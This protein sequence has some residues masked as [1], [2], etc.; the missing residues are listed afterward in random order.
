MLTFL[1][2]ALQLIGLYLLADF[3][4]GIAHYLIDNVLPH[5]RSRVARY[6][7]GENNLHHSK[8]RAML[9]ATRWQRLRV[10]LP[11]SIATLT[12]LGL[13]GLL[14]WQVVTL[15]SMLTVANEIHAFAH[16]TRREN[17]PLVTALQR[18]GFFQSA[19]HH[20]LHHRSPFDCHYCVMSN[21]LNPL[22]DRL[23]LWSRLD[24]MLG[25][26]KPN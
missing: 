8:P 11:F 9:N 23:R 2:I 6:I 16:Q 3:I 18:I 13:L 7:V 22:L 10:P 20:G 17:G 25:L 19:R 21:W 5:W 4:T 24:R 26:H 12:L 1:L 15:V 14:T